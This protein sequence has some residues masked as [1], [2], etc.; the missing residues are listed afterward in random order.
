[1]ASKT[2][3]EF[4]SYKENTLFRGRND[5]EKPGDFFFEFLGVG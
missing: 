4:R 1:V 5:G 3:A 2:E